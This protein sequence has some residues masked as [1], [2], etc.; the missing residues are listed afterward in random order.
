MSHALTRCGATVIGA[1]IDDAALQDSV[2]KAPT[3]EGGAMH[4]IHLDVSAPEEC[5]KAVAQVRERYGDIAVLVNCAGLG[6]PFARGDKNDARP[7]P[8][9]QV[10]AERAWV[11]LAVNLRGPFLLAR[12]VA[13][14]MIARRWGRIVNVTTSFSTMI[15]GGNMS[16][17][18]TKSALEGATASWSADLEGTGVT[19]NVL[20]PGGA[21]DTDMVPSASAHERSKLLS[22]SVMCDPICYLASRESDGVNGKRFIGQFFDSQDPLSSPGCAPVAWPELAAAA[23]KTRAAGTRP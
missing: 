22:P 13:P 12:E 23:L 1:D 7:M 4:T 2:G 10:D 15:R 6:P 14:G 5:R 20:I 21:A 19:A 8:F 3:Q 9:W 11:M 16:Y 18:Q 17:G